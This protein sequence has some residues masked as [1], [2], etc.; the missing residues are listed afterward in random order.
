MG[1][2]KKLN[3]LRLDELKEEC[4]SRGLAYEDLTKE[5]L[6]LSI[7]EYEQQ[8]ER[9][10][11]QK[12]EIDETVGKDTEGDSVNTE[13]EAK[14]QYQYQLEEKKLQLQ[15][16][17]ERMQHEYRMS[18]LELR[19]ANQSVNTVSST[20]TI[21][22]KGPKIPY[23]SEGEDVEIYISTFERIASC[24]KWSRDT[25]AVRLASLLT[26]KAKEAYARMD[27]N[28]G[29]DFGKLKTAILERYD[30]RLKFI[31]KSFV[32]IRKHLMK[33]SKNGVFV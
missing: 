19:K 15:I 29:N 9:A 6:K 17:R 27:L 4:K 22:V 30:L 33:H 18:E 21:G 1:L 32:L 12:P 3:S 16:E 10:G 26:R 11:D 23:F 13:S 25:W 24:N 31:V 20:S 7:I 2:P 8:E 5:Q 28:D 14:T